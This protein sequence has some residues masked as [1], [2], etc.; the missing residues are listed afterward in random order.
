MDGEVMDEQQLIGL[1]GQG[2]IAGALMLII[3]KVGMALVTAVR[4]L[5]AELAE[6]TKSDLA[7]QAEVRGD[8]AAIQVRI[9]TALDITPIRAPKPRA[10]TDPHGYYPPRKPRQGDED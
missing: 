1:V 7:A 2:G 4:E 8:L 5:R 3:Y 10:K 9:D 6:H